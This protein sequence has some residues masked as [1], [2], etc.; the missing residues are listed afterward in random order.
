MIKPLTRSISRLFRDRRGV[1]A[2]EFA[3]IAPFM[4]L[5]YLGSVEISL[6]L[7]IDRKITSISSAL[8]DLVAQDDIITDDEMTDILNAGSVIAAPF[9]PTPLQIRITSVLMDSSDNVEVQWSDAQGM[10]PYSEGSTVTIPS[11]VLERNRSVIMVE[12]NYEYDTMFGELGVSQFNISEIFY[13]R[14]RRSIV[15]SRS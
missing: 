4:I 6:A 12:V 15:V 1:S 8:A 5:L 10:A 2:V 9:D 14:P 11:G 3:L 13:L 7:S